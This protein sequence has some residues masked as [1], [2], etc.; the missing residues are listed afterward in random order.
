MIAPAMAVATA[1]S[2]DLMNA[3]TNVSS[4]NS[5]ETLSSGRLARRRRERADR[6]DQP[7]AGSGTAPM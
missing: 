4:V 1:S 3:S 6:D 7:S 2:I 5:R